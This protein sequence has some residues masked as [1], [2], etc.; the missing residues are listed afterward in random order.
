[1]QGNITDYDVVADLKQIPWTHIDGGEGK[2]MDSQLIFDGADG[3]PEATRACIKGFISE[4]HFHRAS[5]F[6]LLLSG[7]MQ[8]PTFCIEGVAVHYTDHCVAYGPHSRAGDHDFI[9]VH[10]KPAGLTR[11]KELKNKEMRSV[12]N[13]RGRHLHGS[14]C[15]A[16]PE[17][18]PGCPGV[19]QKTLVADPRGVN[20]K[21]LECPAGTELKLDEPTYG[22]FELIT[23]GSALLNDREL[24]EETLRFVRSA[25]AETPLICGPSGATVIVMTYD[26]DAAQTYGGS[27]LEDLKIVLP[28]LQAQ[29]HE[30]NGALKSRS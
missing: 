19:T 6:Q 18:M 9:V 4:P 3:G 14:E 11:L 15:D 2:S 17:P 7:V 12:I 23:K 26:D 1:M 25:T 28:K 29:A 30:E 13:R 22:R 27:L 8:F 5:Q 20:V 16:W 10:A 21:I 24:G